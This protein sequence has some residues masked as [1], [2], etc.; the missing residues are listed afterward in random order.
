MVDMECVKCRAMIHRHERCNGLLEIVYESHGVCLF[1]HLLSVFLSSS[2]RM[3]SWHSRRSWSRQRMTWTST[4][5]PWRTPR[6]NWRS[7]R[8]KPWMWV[9]HPLS[10]GLTL[11]HPVGPLRKL[12]AAPVWQ[13]IMQILTCISC[14][15][16]SALHSHLDTSEVQWGSVGPFIRI[17]WGFKIPDRF[18]FVLVS[19]GTFT[20]ISNSDEID[21]M[22]LM[23]HQVR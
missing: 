20:D 2:W 6:R 9:G 5:K 17:C 1:V 7:L 19:A 23:L 10:H 4:L 13:M 8:R 22:G 21:C 12:L 11:N 18:V 3:T 14:A 16:M 15:Y